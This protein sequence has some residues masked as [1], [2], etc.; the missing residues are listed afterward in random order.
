MPSRASS[1]TTTRSPY[2][3]SSLVE[4]VDVAERGGPENHPARAGVEPPRSPRG[5]PQSATD[6]HRYIDRV[7]DPRDVLE[8]HRHSRPGAVEVDDVEPP[9]AGVDPSLG[10]VH[11]VGVVFGALGE[12]SAGQPD[13]LAAEDVDRGQ[14]DHAR[15]RAAARPTQPRPQQLEAPSRDDFSGWN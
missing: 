9:G 14:E 1:E 2:S 13:G 11:R 5:G 3:A 7:C 4:K 12:V 6:L 8:V 15:H 10:R